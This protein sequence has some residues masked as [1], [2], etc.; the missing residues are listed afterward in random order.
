MADDAAELAFVAAVEEIARVKAAGDTNLDLSDTA[1]HALTSI[2]PELAS[3]TKL[4][5]LDLAVV[6]RRWW[7]FEGGV[8][9]G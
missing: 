2:P 1:F 8:I 5:R 6:S 9:S 4:M 7:K 3:L